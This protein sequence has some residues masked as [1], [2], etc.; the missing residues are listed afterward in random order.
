MAQKS[1]AG[2]KSIEGQIGERVL[3][4]DRMIGRKRKAEFN[5]THIYKFKY[6]HFIADAFN[7][8]I[9]MVV[10]SF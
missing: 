6:F 5:A 8:I 1:V 2:D 4:R 7:K 10:V 3:E 9:S